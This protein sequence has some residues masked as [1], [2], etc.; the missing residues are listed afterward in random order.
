LLIG[1]SPGT[2]QVVVVI[3]KFA[4]FQLILFKL[5]ICFS[6]VSDE[7]END[8]YSHS[9]SKFYLFSLSLALKAKALQAKKHN[10]DIVAGTKTKMKFS[11]ASL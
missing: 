6:I 7:D 11:T 10:E 1:L 3:D 9:K 5:I 2:F 8:D 4:L